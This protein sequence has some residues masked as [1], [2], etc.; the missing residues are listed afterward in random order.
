MRHW[1]FAWGPFVSAA[2]LALPSTA[3]AQPRDMEPGSLLIFPFYDARP[4]S[5]CVLTVT[6]L[7]TSRVRHEGQYREGDVQIH[8]HYVEGERWLTFDRAEIL[9]PGDT[10]SVI[11]ADH[12]PEGDFGFVW[13]QAEDP[14]TEQPIDFDFLIGDILVARSTDNAIWELPSVAFRSLADE[15]GPIGSSRA[16][17]SWADLNGNGQVD[18]DGFEYDFFP[19]KLYVSRFF[20]ETDLSRTKLILL[21]T[22][23]PSTDNTIGFLFWNNREQQFSRTFRFRCWWEGSLS[24]ISLIVKNL[25]GD[26]TELGPAFPQTGWVQIDGKRAVR[27]GGSIIRED[28]PILGFV[29]E[30]LGGPRGETSARLLHH[31]G[32]QDGGRL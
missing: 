12:N 2:L 26:P 21:T 10:L 28:P 19:D 18:F 6:N 25:G 1:R 17:H 22:A 20:Q 3:Q 32:A 8:Y 14:E 27:V 11:V 15:S 5:V 29:I 7:N 31:T 30:E 9:T 24:D 4:D 13:I 16:G 23:D